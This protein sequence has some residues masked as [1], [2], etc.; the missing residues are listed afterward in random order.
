MSTT[1]SCIKQLAGRRLLPA[2]ALPLLIASAASVDA[3]DICGCENNPD[4][5]G[6]FSRLDPATWPP[7]QSAGPFGM[8]QPTVRFAK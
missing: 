5:L 7:I 2:L 4:S 8:P 3:L 1:T 6:D